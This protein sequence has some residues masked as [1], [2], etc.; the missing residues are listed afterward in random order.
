VEKVAICISVSSDLAFA[1]AVTFINFISIHGTEGFHFRLFSDSKLP[2]MV[3]VFQKLGAD[4]EVEVFRPPLSWV[5]LWGSRAIAYFSPMVLAKFEGFQLLDSFPRVVWLDYDIVITKSIAELWTR[6]GFDF[7][8]A[9]S[10]QPKGS[11]FTIP[12]EV[13]KPDEEGM[14]AGILA[15]RRGF[16]GYGNAASELYKL[17]NTHHSHLY[18]PE[19]AIFDLYLDRHPGFKHWKLDEKFGSYPG[20]EV[21]GN[22]I[23]HAYGSKKFWSGLHND[24]WVNY[25]SEWLSRGGWSWNPILSKCYK[26][27]RAAKHILA[28][29]LLALRIS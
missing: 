7:A 8:Y 13:I 29:V 17:F 3:N 21:P 19:Q 2:R 4:F 24:L 28:R 11:G 16:L 23:L 20:N 26:A 10:S 25:H 22:A 1:A 6:E 9:G 12:P 18:Y 27:V 15:F 5:K 14:S